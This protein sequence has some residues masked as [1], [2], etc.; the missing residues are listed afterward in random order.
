MG[1][2]VKRDAG[3]NPEAWL[4][5]LPSAYQILLVL[6]EGECHG[7]AIMQEINLRTDGAMRLGPGT[8]YRTIKRMLEDGWIEEAGDRHD[9]TLDDERRRF[10]RLTDL[11]VRVARA[12]TQRLTNLVDM[13]R[14]KRLLWPDAPA[15][16]GV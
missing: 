14:S 7:Y 6:A 10:Y 8:L 5:L 11:G 15:F 4:P 1:K 12:E 16:A 9:P 3:P 13:A 2:L